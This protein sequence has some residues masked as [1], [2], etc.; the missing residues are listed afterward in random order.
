MVELYSDT[1]IQQYYI[2]SGC[3]VK[4]LAAKF[5]IS[6]SKADYLIDK[7]LAV[8]KDQMRLERLLDKIELQE[9]ENELN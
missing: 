7:A 3:S 1:Q 8:V 4:E 5:N 9:E 2:N 6:F